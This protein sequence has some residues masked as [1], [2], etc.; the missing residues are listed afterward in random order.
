MA[1]NIEKF[2]D[3]SLF[4]IVR[5]LAEEKG[6]YHLNITE[7]LSNDTFLKIL[8]YKNTNTGKNLFKYD[9]VSGVVMTYVRSSAKNNDLIEEF[10]K[11][12]GQ[13][14][15]IDFKLNLFNHFDKDKLKQSKTE[16]AKQE[17]IKGNEETTSPYQLAFKKELAK[18]SEDEVEKI[19]TGLNTV[20]RESLLSKPIEKFVKVSLD[21][22]KTYMFNER[23][24][25]F[26]DF[27]ES[28][29][30]RVI[31]D[32]FKVKSITPSLISNVSKL[33][34][35]EVGNAEYKHRFDKKFIAMKIGNSSKYI[36][37][38]IKHEFHE[39]KAIFRMYAKSMAHSCKT[40]YQ[41]YLEPKQIKKVGDDKFEFSLNFYDS[42]DE[43]EV[44]KHFKEN[45]YFYQP[46][47]VMSEDGK[48]TL[49]QYF[50]KSS[51]VN[52]DSIKHMRNHCGQF[53]YDGK[54]QKVPYLT[55]VGRTGKSAFVK[56][57]AHMHHSGARA[58]DLTSDYTFSNEQLLGATFIYNNEMQNAEG[59]VNENK[60][61]EISGS[62]LL[63][64]YRKN[65][66]PL[67]TS[68]SNIYMW[69]VS[70]KIFPA[71]D[72]GDSMVKRID[73]IMFEKKN[74]IVI[75]DIES[76]IIYGYDINQDGLE[77]RNDEGDYTLFLEW[78]MLGTLD[79]LNTNGRCLTTDIPAY[80]KSLNVQYFKKM[81]RVRDFL[82]EV[83][84]V[85]DGTGL[86]EYSEDIKNL[87]IKFHENLGIDKKF[88]K[89]NIVEDIINTINSKE[90]E[91]ARL[92]KRQPIEVKQIR[93]NVIENGVQRKRYCVNL[94]VK[95]MCDELEYTMRMIDEVKFS[96]EFIS[97]TNDVD[98]KSLKDR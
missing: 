39:G 69:V 98:R 6:N 43:Y 12:A 4:P 17:I 64:I 8:N 45:V 68:A 31:E 48:G 95:G 18:Y 75:D 91:K 62:D 70:N 67:N 23:S 93:K 86:Y 35:M 1:N 26:E 81:M 2:D 97:A 49:L 77:M 10:A 36:W 19:A 50:L 22:D 24:G 53:W 92:E 52:E 32:E 38:H 30:K 96:P 15:G 46:R 85:P 74:D 11:N 57:V 65:K 90:K 14:F 63:C 61:K 21:D 20:S 59:K 33:I 60:F 80:C 9:E 27:N 72:S 28:I 51:I 13:E 73:F 94:R 44:I 55:D 56:L 54:I 66:N 3:D 88:V 89:S 5:I 41:G 16:K 79:I 37:M 42:I 34:S 71:T 87:Y 82:D 58:F 84:I 76:K 78:T 25:I 7:S 83:E 40:W 47:D 29:V